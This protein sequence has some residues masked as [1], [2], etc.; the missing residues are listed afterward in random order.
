MAAL[1]A[2]SNSSKW[3]RAHL[4][5][6]PSDHLGLSLCHAT[7]LIDHEGRS[8]HYPQC[9][10]E[11]LFLRCYVLI[12]GQESCIWKEAYAWEVVGKG[13]GISGDLLGGNDLRCWQPIGV[14]EVGLSPP[15]HTSRVLG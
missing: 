14:C 13:V 9:R 3:T 11:H 8:L 1:S 2:D 4:C 10:Y 12:L 6:W 5:R 7:Y 15:E